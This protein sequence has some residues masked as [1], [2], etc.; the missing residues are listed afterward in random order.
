MTESGATK[1]PARQRE[2]AASTTGG[3]VRNAGAK[4]PTPLLD[5]NHCTARQLSLIPGV[6][7]EVGDR[8]VAT[9]RRLGGSFQYFDQLHT[10]KGVTRVVVQ[11]LR[12]RV[13]VPCEKATS[14]GEPEGYMRL[15]PVQSQSSLLSLNSLGDVARRKA[16]ETAAA[17]QKKSPKVTSRPSYG[18]KKSRTPTKQVSTPP[19]KTVKVQRNLTKTKTP[20]GSSKIHGK[21]TKTPAT[22]R[23]RPSNRQAA[24]NRTVEGK[25]RLKSPRKT[26]K[27][28]V[29]SKRPPTGR[30][31]GKTKSKTPAKRPAKKT[32]ASA[33]R[34]RSRTPKRATKKSSVRASL[35]SK[36]PR[37]TPPRR[38][39][40][41]SVSP[42]TKKI[43]TTPKRAKAT[44]RREP[45]TYQ[46]VTSPVGQST[47]TYP[48]SRGR[49]ST[50]QPPVFVLKIETSPTQQQTA[51]TTPAETAVAS[52]KTPQVEV[53]ER[54]VSSGSR[55]RR[56]SKKSANK[57]TPEVK[58]PSVEVTPGDSASA[59]AGSKTPAVPSTTAGANA[60][61]AVEVE[62][63]PAR[64]RSRSSVEAVEKWLESTAR[65][66]TDLPQQEQGDDCSSRHTRQGMEDITSEYKS[67]VAYPASTA[68]A[69]RA[70]GPQPVQTDS[71]GWNVAEGNQ[72]QPSPEE[73]PAAKDAEGNDTQG[74]EK[75]PVVVEQ[76]EAGAE[77]VGTPTGRERRR[78]HHRHRRSRDEPSP[79]RRRRSFDSGSYPTCSVL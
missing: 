14:I 27:S 37:P 30:L 44:P 53:E 74:N 20:T 18:G 23:A 48:S 39:K 45:V 54:S 4:T 32:V 50:R 75:E 40:A 79:K 77:V 71:Q 49:A 72:T 25:S 51:E 21:S 7:R 43:K 56:S 24:A 67:A 63:D 68:S 55:S 58:E 31:V 28:P 60:P 76:V 1:G 26:G 73:P 34:S 11:A 59:T 10:I 3:N 19:R 66:S 8:I 12:G 9:R 57:R 13:Q 38:K 46:V 64:L 52:S 35:A 15:G 16:E 41:V 61:E 36:P 47:W 17:K 78:R 22:S 29:S 2:K 5:I 65:Y 6:S 62:K 33:S 69:E 70:K 42:Q